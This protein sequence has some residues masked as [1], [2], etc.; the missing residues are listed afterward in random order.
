MTHT[1]NQVQQ[2]AVRAIFKGV[3]ERAIAPATDATGDDVFETRAILLSASQPGARMLFQ[4]IPT[5]LTLT[6]SNHGYIL[7]V[8]QRLGMLASERYHGLSCGKPTCSFRGKS[9]VELM[10]HVEVCVAG[11]SNI[12]RHDVLVSEFHSLSMR[13][14]LPTRYEPRG[15]VPAKRMKGGRPAKG[16]PDLL[17]INYPK[18]AEGTMFDV[19]VTNVRKCGK[20]LKRASIACTAAGERDKEKVKD[21]AKPCEYVNFRFEP[22]SFEA[23]GAFGQGVRRFLAMAL[24]FIEE[25]Q[26]ALRTPGQEFYTRT[27]AAPT[28]Y[29][30]RVQ[31]IVVALARWN[32]NMVLS[33]LRAAN[34]MGLPR[35]GAITGADQ[36]PWKETANIWPA[37]TT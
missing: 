12:M 22:L 18:P 20:A 8:R 11:M 25:E 7:A 10:R 4:V 27:W 32:S 36:E 37:G 19:S 26:R 5:S 6:L 16:G 17:V 15:L 24:N 3:Y 30:Y 14:G 1:A 13:M 31:R 28:E 2:N 23:Q 29:Q 33:G 35:L 9:T 34:G 21:W